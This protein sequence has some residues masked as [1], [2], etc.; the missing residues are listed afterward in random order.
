MTSPPPVSSRGLPSPPIIK[1][2]RSDPLYPTLQTEDP[3]ELHLGS[4]LS[5]L[6]SNAGS[7]SSTVPYPMTPTTP[8]T[9]EKRNTIIDHMFHNFTDVRN[10]E[11]HPP[12]SPSRPPPVVPRKSYGGVSEK[13]QPLAPALDDNVKTFNTPPQHRTETYG[14]TGLKNLGNTCYM[15]SIIQCM[16]GTIPLARYLLNGTYK[17]HINRENRLGSKG[18]FAEAF[19]TLIRHL[20]EGDYAFVSP[21][22]FKVSRSDNKGGGAMLNNFRIYQAD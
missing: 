12:P 18:L 19:A 2:V 14:K 3:D 5:V 17:M 6:S 1:D 21:V 13:L 9:L 22:T 4:S 8:G 7:R 11:F 20:W 10:P 15:N 16:S